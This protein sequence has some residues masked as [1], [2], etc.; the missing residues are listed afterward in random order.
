MFTDSQTP[1]SQV[2]IKILTLTMEKHRAV[3]HSFV[4][5]HEHCP[6]RPYLELVVPPEA[7]AVTSATFTTDSRDQGWADDKSVSYTW[8]EVAL[9]RPAGRSDVAAIRIQHNKAGEDEFFT[10]TT[11]WN[12]QSTSPRAK[13]WL[14]IVQPGDVIQLIP[15]AQFPGWV[16]I[17]RQGSIE[18]E[19]QVRVEDENLQQGW[20]TSP[21]VASPGLIYRLDYGNRQI[22][23][24]VVKPGTYESDIEAEFEY[25]NLAGSS[26][27]H[28][29]FH[30]LSYYWGD[31]TKS[32][33]I[34]IDAKGR[35][36]H[37]IGISSTLERAIRRFRSP[38]VPLRIWIDAICINQDDL[39]E[40]AQQVAMMGS[41]YSGADMVR[42]WLDDYVLG[43]DT[44][45]RIIRDIYNVNKRVCLGGSQCQCSSTKH[46]LPAEQLDEITQPKEWH[47]FGYTREVF[48]RYHA[49]K[50]FDASAI[51]AAGGEGEVHFTNF[52][53]TFFHHPWFQ[54]VWVV[55]EAILS[56]KTVVYSTSEEIPWE[57]L[58]LINEMASTPEY[59]GEARWSVQ[60]RDSMPAIWNALPGRHGRTAEGKT[61]LL[62]ILDVFLKALDLKATNP[63]DKLFAL[64]A[65]G[66]ETSEA[67]K[68]PSLLR[69][70]YSKPLENVMADFTRW[71][72]LEYHSLNIL[73]FLHCQSTRAWRRT[74]WDE[75]P[76]LNTPAL[77]GPSWALGTDGYAQCSSMTLREQFP[78]LLPTG[79]ADTVP[80]EDLIRLADD[81]NP[82]EL[83]LRG[84]KVGEIVALGHPP[85]DMV[86][87]ENKDKQML[88]A[89]FN[90]LF[91]PSA[92][93]GVWLLQG[94]NYHEEHWDPAA[95]EYM[96]L[97][98]IQAHFSY[99]PAPC[100]HTLLPAADGGSGYTCYETT[101]LP[102]CVERCF[103]VL[104]NG[105]YGLC[106]W[107]AQ[108]GDVVTLLQGGGVP[109]LLRPV[110]EHLQS[111][112]DTGSNRYQFV[113][114]CFAEGIADGKTV[115]DGD[116][117]NSERF[118]L[119]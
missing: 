10:A 36:G 22:R 54:R 7:S 40:R 1:G 33:S 26:D 11:H 99:I 96:L 119:V 32:T 114:E 97:D 71:W 48:G 43:L 65:F 19:Y 108:R 29:G 20:E 31:S 38:D 30:A 70:D 102:S 51:D 16:N 72:I 53:Q 57:E 84:Y 56:H 58:L 90:R 41:I 73:S 104:S 6:R 15:R 27:Q 28:I 75:D 49:M 87:A 2:E 107:T 67:D 76:Q 95:L 45:L 118:V 3:R 68:I 110:P 39:E 85:Q 12:T 55:Q 46:T 23:V 4:Q 89:V 59:A 109:Y 112:G 83:A 88:A 93:M 91:D 117:G 61:K 18:I 14:G 116:L 62:P 103:F 105:M 74:L 52:M 9:R 111:N 13:W 50:S 17:I 37:K 69:P 106:P 21:G 34:S 35:V 80:D 77:S 66:H 24:L 101:D 44:A 78:S 25:V 92:R 81:S 64:L 86:S 94:V 47:S 63:R 115:G 79:A 98:H 42:I 82:L 5:V 8:F 113:G 60:A 100:Q